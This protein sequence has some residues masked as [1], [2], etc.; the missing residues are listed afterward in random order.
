MHQNYNN[1]KKAVGW[2]EVEDENL[3]MIARAFLKLCDKKGLVPNLFNQ[4]QLQE[5]IQQTLPPI[6]NEE[7]EYYKEN[8]LI[9]AFSKNTNPMATINDREVGEPALHFHEFI[10]LLGLIAR[11]MAADG[12]IDGQLQEFYC[13]KL[14][15]THVPEAKMSDITYG[16]ILE[17]VMAGEDEYGSYEDEDDQEEYVP[18]DDEESPKPMRRPRR[19]DN[20]DKAVFELIEQKQREE[21]NINIDW[22]HLTTII[23]E[24]PKIPQ[25][26]VVQK[27]NPPPYA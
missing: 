22:D 6:S 20:Y 9:E 3:P 1:P 5:Y 23:D 21:M 27:I 2:Q 15:F 26:P 7:L 12:Q 13:S 8:K 4:E 14:E 19:P 16:M 18:V 11:T 10:Y 17:R 24:C 25:P